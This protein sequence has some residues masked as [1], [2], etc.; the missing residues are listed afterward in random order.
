MQYAWTVYK[1]LRYST[2]KCR[3]RCKTEPQTIGSIKKRIRTAL[4][5]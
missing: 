3:V 4:L 1:N 2:K 5:A